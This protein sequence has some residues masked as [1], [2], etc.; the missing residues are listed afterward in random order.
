MVGVSLDNSMRLNAT[1][2]FSEVSYYRANAG[3]VVSGAVVMQVAFCVRFACAGTEGLGSSP[4]GGSEVSFSNARSTPC[5][6]ARCLSWPAA[7]ERC[8]YDAD[9]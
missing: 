8:R 1:S 7:F 2:T 3:V 4:C 6:K 9:C 5:R